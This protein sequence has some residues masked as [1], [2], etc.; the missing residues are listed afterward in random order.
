MPCAGT[1]PESFPLAHNEIARDAGVRDL[2]SWPVNSPADPR[3]GLL[4][5][6]GPAALMGGGL[7][8]LGGAGYAFVALAGHTLA[9]GDA[10]AIAAFYL[11]TN[12]LGPGVFVALEQETS[13]AVS[14]GLAGGARLGPIVRRAVRLGAGLL[15]AVGLVLLAVAPVVVPGSFGGRWGLFGALVLGAVTSAVVYLV[16]GVLGGRRRFGGYAATMAAEGLARLL[17]CLLL[18]GVGAAS[19]TG[20]ALLFAGGSL[21]GAAAGLPWLRGKPAASTAARTVTPTAVA[22]VTPGAA[23]GA[24]DAAGATAGRLW[25]LVG[26]TVLGQ[27]VANLA[28]VVVTARLGAD[29]ALAAAFASAFVLVRIPVTLF[30]PVQ[31][32]QLPALTRAAIRG[33]TADFRR[34]LRFVLL[35]AAG[36]GAVG[37][38]L[39][40]LVGPLAV[41]VLFGARVR[42]SAV[43]LGAL[44]AGTL[45]LVLAQVLQPA[46][47]ALRR[48]PAVTRSWLAGSAVL[49]GLLFL[50]VAPVTAAVVAQLAGSVTVAG[51]M[52]FALRR[53]WSPTGIDATDHAHPPVRVA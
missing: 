24:A 52:W 45:L 34:R 2:Y 4:S 41:Q 49:T 51:G 43:V 48:H 7:L 36:V 28:P 35:A 44:G 12:I 37:V 22:A 25:L 38:L 39:G 20:Y 46:L 14:A 31:A 32:M 5:R 10:A 26:S 19:G 33:D 29:T 42:L 17:P 16:R 23:P 18:A 50:P 9:T 40:V 6:L 13:R 3:S 21:C 47:L 1:A 11:L 53:A 30:A 8:V 15:G 27:L